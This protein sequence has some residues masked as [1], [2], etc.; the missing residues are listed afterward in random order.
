MEDGKRQ[1]SVAKEVEKR[2]VKQEENMSQ[3]VIDSVSIAENL[4]GKRTD[5]WTW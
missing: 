1:S 2:P 4:S 3:R 5:H